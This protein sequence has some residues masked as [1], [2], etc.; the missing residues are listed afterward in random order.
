M[1]GRKLKEENLKLKKELENIE[2]ELNK[3]K[4]DVKEQQGI[5]NNL[6]VLYD[7]QKNKLYC[8][9]EENKE[10]KNELKQKESQLFEA[11]EKLE[12]LSKKYRNL[13]AKTG[14]TIARKN[15]LEVQVKD[16]ELKLAESMSDKYLVRK[17]P[18]QKPKVQ[19]ITKI[20]NH[21]V[22]TQAKN[23]LKNKNGN[24][25]EYV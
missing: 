3:Y 13:I 2:K 11:E 24:E 23:I 21:V 19:K 4:N 20:K 10:L 25:E 17:L 6:T 18:A 9:L 22:N 8:C 7:N 5:A 16:L 14:G 15:K 1:F 12:K